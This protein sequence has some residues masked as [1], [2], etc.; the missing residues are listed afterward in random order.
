MN[1]PIPALYEH[2]HTAEAMWIRLSLLTVFL[3]VNG[4]DSENKLH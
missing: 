2:S 4:K 3:A 1:I